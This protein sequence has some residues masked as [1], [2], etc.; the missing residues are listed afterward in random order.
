MYSLKISGMEFAPTKYGK[1]TRNSKRNERPK[2]GERERGGHDG[3]HGDA[4]VLHLSADDLRGGGRDACENTVIREYDSA[5]SG[6]AAVCAVVAVDV[7]PGG[8]RGVA[9]GAHQPR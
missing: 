2:E 8:K 6:E 4:E 5:A 3:G 7:V 1:W 9:A